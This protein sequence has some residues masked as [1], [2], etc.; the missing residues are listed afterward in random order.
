MEIIFTIIIIALLIRLGGY[1][2][3]K[4]LD[5]K[6][7]EFEDEKQQRAQQAAAERRRTAVEDGQQKQILASYA[8][9]G[10]YINDNTVPLWLLEQEMDKMKKWG[11]SEEQAYS[12]VKEILDKH[13]LKVDEEGL[14]YLPSKFI[15]EDEESVAA[16]YCSK[17]VYNSSL[18]EAEKDSRI[19]EILRHVY[20]N[21][22]E[23]Q[24]GVRSIG[25]DYLLRN[26]TDPFEKPG[27]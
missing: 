8:R 7:A 17:A 27:N 10:L 5:K 25:L 9:I 3:N 22:D 2:L 26:G 4:W 12:E 21:E 24:I 1:L 15:P 14:T 16:Y 20:K 11:L 6:N 23:T 13:E 18:S 19:K